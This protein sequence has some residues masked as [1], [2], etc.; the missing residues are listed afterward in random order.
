MSIHYVNGASDKP[1]RHNPVELEDVV[2]LNGKSSERIVQNGV[3]FV[4]E[5]EAKV[6]GLRFSKPL[7]MDAKRILLEFT[8]LRRLDKPGSDTGQ[9]L[10]TSATVESGGRFSV[11]LSLPM[12]ENWGK[13]VRVNSL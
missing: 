12:P 3:D 4:R 8:F 7:P 10:D 9:I 11:R 5:E 2:L 1:L 6:F 13:Q